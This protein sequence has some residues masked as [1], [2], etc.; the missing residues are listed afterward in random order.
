MISLNQV[1][2]IRGYIPKYSDFVSIV[3]I[4]GNH[5][6]KE[7]SGNVAANGSKRVGISL[8]AAW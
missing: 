7:G 8:Y 3:N 1:L 4:L 6:S 5:F 2:R